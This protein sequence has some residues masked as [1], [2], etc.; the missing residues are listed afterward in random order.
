MLHLYEELC[1]E[2][3]PA[4]NPSYNWEN[5]IFYI[6]SNSVENHA[7]RW[8]TFSHR[9]VFD[10]FSK[11]LN[12]LIIARIS[13]PVVEI[14]YDHYRS[15]GLCQFTAIAHRSVWKARVSNIC[16]ICSGLIWER[17]YLGLR[18]IWQIVFFVVF[19]GKYLHCAE[20]RRR[21]RPNFGFPQ[22]L[23]CISW[24]PNSHSPSFTM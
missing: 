17:Q 24:W 22:I 8:R 18:R 10:P 20:V 12:R 9:I 6:V 11:L 16:D 14:Q 1:A 13:A 5:H 4:N 3:N 15:F 21:V 7:Q 2:E 19:W 23:N